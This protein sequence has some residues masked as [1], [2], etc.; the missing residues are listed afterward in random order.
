NSSAGLRSAPRSRP[1]TSSPALVSSRARIAPVQPMPTMTASASFNRVAIAT[2]S[3]KICD[4]LRLRDVT[5]VAVGIDFVG[6]NGGKTGETDHL[7]CNLVAI[8][9]IDRIGEEALHGDGEELIEERTGIEVPKLGP[10]FLHCFDCLHALGGREE[11][12]ILAVG[13]PC[14]GVGGGNSR[15]EKFPRCERKLIALLGLAFVQ[16]TAPIHFSAAAP[17]APELAVNKDA[18]P[19]SLPEGESSSAGMR[20]STAA[21]MKAASGAVSVTNC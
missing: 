13:L 12:E 7:P 17:G 21:T 4:R 9:A 16:R 6:I 2:A 14:P 20:V 19:Q 3:G 10:S 8:A 1:T 11:I 5:L 15:G 18:T